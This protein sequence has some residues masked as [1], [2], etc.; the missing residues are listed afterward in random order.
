MVSSQRLSARGLTILFALVIFLTLTALIVTSISLGRA[1]ERPL[2]VRI[3]IEQR[4]VEA[5]VGDQMGQV[6]APVIVVSN[7]SD[8]AIPRF[9]IDI[10]GQYFLYRDSPLEAGQ[11]LTLLQEQFF[12]KS[13][14]RFV[15]GRWPITH[16][17]AYGQLPSG[18]R[19][20]LEYRPA[21][22]K[23]QTP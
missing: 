12:T 15:P 17:T 20:V 2:P 1:Q 18:G 7:E 5:K 22:E 16:V 6:M 14:Q 8:H 4:M 10:N 19:G 9:S 11:E 21:E 13:N 3:A 23:P